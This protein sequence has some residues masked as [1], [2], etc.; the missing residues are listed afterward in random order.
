MA[1][2][3]C[4]EAW[5]V[6]DE[7]VAW[8]HEVKLVNTTRLKDLGIGQQGRKTYRMDAEV[9][10]RAV[11]SGH[12]PQAHVLSPHRRESRTHLIMRRTLVETDSVL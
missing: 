9:L 10:A 2:E 3:A 6:H 12:I 4:R 5:H 8:G 1:I 11:E 7:L